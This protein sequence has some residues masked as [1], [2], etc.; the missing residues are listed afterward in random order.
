MLASHKSPIADQVY[1]Q[2]NRDLLQNNL[3]KLRLFTV[4]I[5]GILYRASR[6]TKGEV[7]Q[8]KKTL[9]EFSLWY[10]VNPNRVTNWKQQTAK[11]A[12]AFL[13]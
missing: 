4:A 12:A 9:A 8:I 2:A 5:M 3:A 10:G 13:G 11:W 6:G 1:C 7:I